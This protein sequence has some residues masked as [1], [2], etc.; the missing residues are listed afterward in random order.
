MGMSPSSVT[1]SC[2][3]RTTATTGQR[4]TRITSMRSKGLESTLDLPGL[5]ATLAGQKVKTAASMWLSLLLDLWTVVDDCHDTTT[6]INNV[7]FTF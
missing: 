1:R 4:F 2:S 5:E 7:F 3:R 6:W